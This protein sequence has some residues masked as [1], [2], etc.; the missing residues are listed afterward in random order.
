V[1][2]QRVH[3]AISVGRSN[4][5]EKLKV[6]EP[7]AVASGI[8]TQAQKVRDHEEHFAQVESLSRSLRLAVLYRSSVVR[9]TDYLVNLD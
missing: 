4:Q 8:K 2:N 9:F 3:Q 7:R 1:R 5:S 6:T